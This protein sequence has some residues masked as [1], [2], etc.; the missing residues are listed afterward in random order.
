MFPRKKSRKCF[1][2]LWREIIK[3]A[4]FV[5]AGMIAAV[6]VI[7]PLISRY[8]KRIIKKIHFFSVIL[9]Y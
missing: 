6:F 8:I 1:A 3:A 7:K 5:P 9:T 4:A 2:K